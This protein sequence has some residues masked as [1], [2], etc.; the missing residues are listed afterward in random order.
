MYDICVWNCLD[1]R[2]M[3]TAGWARS[4]VALIQV[5]SVFGRWYLV[6]S[7]VALVSAGACSIQI[8]TTLNYLLDLKQVFN[9]MNSKQAQTRLSLKS[10]RNHMARRHSDPSLHSGWIGTFC[11]AERIA[12]RRLSSTR[13]SAGSA[14]ILLSVNEDKS[15]NEIDRWWSHCTQSPWGCEKRRTCG[16]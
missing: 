7:D 16:R 12:L 5:L 10:P 1:C 8:W 4:S 11:S 6:V 9:Q 14:L 3:K 2:F 15:S 13:P